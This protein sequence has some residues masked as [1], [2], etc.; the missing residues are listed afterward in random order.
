MSEAVRPL[1]RT[2]GA[3]G[4]RLA[5]LAVADARFHVHVPGAT[6]TGKT[7]LVSNMVLA[8]A[9]AGRGAV[10]LDPKGDMVNDLLGRLPAAVAGRLVLIDPSETEAPAALNILDGPDPELAAD[11]VV[12][13]F[14]RIWGAWWGPR[15]DDILRCACLTLARVP[16][17]TLADIPALLTEPAV[18]AALAGAA[19]ERDPYLRGFWRWY[20]ALPESGQAAAA[21][22]V[23]SRLR[24]VLTRRFAADLLGSAR[25]SFDMRTVLDN[26]G[27]LLARL[28]KG[29][30][31]D[32]TARLAGSLVI[33]KA[34]QAALTRAAVPEHARRDAAL[35]VDECHNFLNLPGALESILDEARGYRLSLVLAHQ[36]LGQLPRELAAS[37][38]ANARNKVCFTL[39][40]D[41]ARVM[42]RQLGPVLTET[43]LSHLGRYQAACRLVAGGAD[44]AGFTVRTVPLPRPVPGRAD[45]LREAARKFG[46]TREQ[47]RADELRRRHPGGRLA[48]RVPPG[49]PSGD[50]PGVPP[51]VLDTPAETRPPGGPFP[52][53]TGD[54]GRPADESDSWRQS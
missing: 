15:M 50:S 35:Y 10:V 23:L 36:H 11:Q 51:G 42:A 32:D 27:L 16:G 28:P 37:V 6:G 13:V 20:D 3:G 39:S 31:G 2:E 52:H 9:R 54:G 18:R 1:G 25:S 14:R 45:M 12:S 21:G 4:R 49:V 24:A 41:D 26:G 53:V 33:A 38:A 47:R 17:S 29:Q 44:T 22:P 34:W 8:D 46:R 7:T 40:P 5:G 43:D 30:I 48:R 19:S